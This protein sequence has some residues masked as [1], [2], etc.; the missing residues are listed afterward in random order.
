MPIPETYIGGSYTQPQPPPLPP[1][2]QVAAE[3]LARMSPEE[4]SRFQH[5]ARMNPPLQV[6]L[7]QYSPG[8]PHIRHSLCVARS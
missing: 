7:L 5:I 6:R 3:Q 8:G 4:R 1:R 2:S